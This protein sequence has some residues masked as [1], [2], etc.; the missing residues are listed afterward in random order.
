MPGFDGTGPLGAGPMT[1]G[2]RGFCN[3]ATAG[4]RLPFFGS[5]GFNRGMG[6]GRGFRG[7]MGRGMRGGFGGGYGWYPPAH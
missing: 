4:Y 6:F 1:G 3:P 7:G 5:A 2:A